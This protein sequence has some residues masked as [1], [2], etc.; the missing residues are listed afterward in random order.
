MVYIINFSLHNILNSV[1]VLEVATQN[2]KS[3]R[4]TRQ[5]ISRHSVQV[6][7]NLIYECFCVD[8]II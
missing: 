1:Y 7:I 4:Y 6:K 2:C 8:I 5:A 3:R